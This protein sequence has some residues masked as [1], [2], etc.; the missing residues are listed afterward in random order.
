MTKI[1]SECGKEVKFLKGKYYSPQKG[2]EIF[3]CNECLKKVK[4]GKKN[5][6]MYQLF[7]GLGAVALINGSIGYFVDYFREISY[8][9]LVVGFVF[10]A[11]AL[12][13]KFRETRKKL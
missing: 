1:C 7:G 13:M 8:S 11:I 6:S 4:E 9:F 12:V 5:F 10:I 2:K 3:L